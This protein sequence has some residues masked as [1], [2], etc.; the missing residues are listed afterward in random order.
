MYIRFSSLKL[1]ILT[2]HQIL[3]KRTNDTNTISNKRIKDIRFS[4]CKSQTN[5]SNQIFQTN[6]ITQLIIRYNQLIN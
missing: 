5:Y 3:T 2:N 6:Q 1:D 4:I